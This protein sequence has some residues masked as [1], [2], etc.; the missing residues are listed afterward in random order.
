MIASLRGR[1][2][3][4]VSKTM[5]IVVVNSI[6][7]VVWLVLEE[8]GRGSNQGILEVSSVIGSCFMML[9]GAACLRMLGFM[10]LLEIVVWY[11]FVEVSV[12]PLFSDGAW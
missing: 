11:G 3:Y 7:W 4:C 10:R 8:Q 6:L 5:V 1:E 2:T 9:C 12:M